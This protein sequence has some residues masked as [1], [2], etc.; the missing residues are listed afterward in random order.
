[1]AVLM[2]IGAQQGV[3]GDSV[4]RVEALDPC[5]VVIERRLADLRGPVDDVAQ[6]LQ[7]REAVADHGAVDVIGCQQSDLAL[8]VAKGA[9]RHVRQVMRVA[10]V[11]PI[12]IEQLGRR[13]VDSETEPGGTGLP[14]GGRRRAE[15]ERRQHEGKDP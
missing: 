3:D 12:V 14:G 6:L 5:L 8:R 9:R 13:F 10:G 15:C 11:P 2:V 4:Q 1:M 7:R